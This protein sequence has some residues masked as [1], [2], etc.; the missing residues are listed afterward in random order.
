MEIFYFNKDRRRRAYICYN[1]KYMRWFVRQSI[2]GGRVCSFVEYYEYYKSKICND[3]LTIISEVLNVNGNFSEYI[4]ASLKYKSK[5]FIL[6]DKQY[7]CRIND[8]RDEDVEEKEN[9]INERLSQLPIHQI[10]KTNKIR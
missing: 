10:I 1:D 4:E 6:F 3:I 9:Y 5:H 2:K 7:E 8:Y